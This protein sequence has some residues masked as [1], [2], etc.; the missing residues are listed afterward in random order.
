MHP[1]IKG[2]SMN[3]LTGLVAKFQNLKTLLIL[4]IPS[5]KEVKTCRKEK[6]RFK[7]ISMLSFF[8]NYDRVSEFIT[9]Y[10]MG[11]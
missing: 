8:K 11:T 1:M 6:Q 3:K 2:L 7:K 4:I 5:T 9:N 10:K